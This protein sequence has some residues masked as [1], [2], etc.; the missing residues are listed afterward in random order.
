MNKP[1]ELV[2]LTVTAVDA[3]HYDDP[4]GY[5]TIRLTVEDGRVFEIA[6]CSCCDGAVFNEVL[7]QEP[8]TAGDSKEG[9]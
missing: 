9:S 3:T 7:T 5:E 4:N 6:S 1:S 2:G 8:A